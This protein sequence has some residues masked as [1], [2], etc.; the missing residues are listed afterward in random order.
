MPKRRDF[1]DRILAEQSWESVQAGTW[2]DLNLEASGDD[3]AMAI[4]NMYLYCQQLL[5]EGK[6]KL[7]MQKP[8]RTLFAHWP[9]GHA[10]VLTHLGLHVIK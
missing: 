9:A 2:R 10:Q 3:R 7:L 8:M 1:V 5:A 6:H 4:K